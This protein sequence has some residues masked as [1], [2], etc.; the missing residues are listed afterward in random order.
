[1]SDKYILESD[2]TIRPEPDLLTW[3][4]WF[5]KADRRIAQDFLPNGVRVSTVF[6]GLNHSFR[7]GPPLLFETM[8]FGGE[9]DQFQERYRTRDEA[10]AG[11]A[12]AL[13]LAKSETSKPVAGEGPIP[14][15]VSRR[16]EA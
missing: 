14:P 4:R 13:E 16:G 5:E 12:L 15:D 3:A 10:L 1:M 6:L 11:H 7:S 8:I 2:G 9:H